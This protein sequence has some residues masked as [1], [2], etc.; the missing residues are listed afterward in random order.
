MPRPKS[1]LPRIVEILRYLEADIA[2]QYTRRM[3]EKVFML[4]ADQAMELMEL[5]GYSERPRPGVGGLVSRDSLLFYVRNS[6]DGQ[7]ALIDYERRKKLA[8]RLN[9]A[10]GDLKL[11]GIGLRT[12]IADGERARL[13]DLP[14][15]SI[16]PGLMQVV[17]TPGD[18]IDLLDTLF[19]FIKAVSNDLATRVGSAPTEFE[20]LCA[21]KPDEPEQPPEKPVEHADLQ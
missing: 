13:A 10:E 17:F 9:A 1:W 7:L 8:K 19:R 4:G 14:N 3:V 15:V 2:P 16:E 11:R 18:G 5:A 20:K 12:S 6:R 21:A